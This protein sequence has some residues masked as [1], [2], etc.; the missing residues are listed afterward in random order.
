RS[1]ALPTPFPHPIHSILTADH[2]PLFH[3]KLPTF[4]IFPVRSA[5]PRCVPPL[6]HRS[7]SSSAVC[8]PFL[9]AVP[10]SVLP[11]FDTTYSRCRL[12]A[13]GREAHHLY[14]TSISQESSI[15]DI[16]YT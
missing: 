1:C 15:P 7:M 12:S 5:V 4:C 2:I 6:P 8:P 11:L 9:P 3:A 14:L 16:T 10:L 13:A